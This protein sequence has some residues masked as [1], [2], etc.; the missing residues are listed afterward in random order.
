M[1]SDTLSLKASFQSL[2]MCFA[3]V[4]SKTGG[5]VRLH[6]PELSDGIVGV[7]DSLAALLSHDAHP[8]VRCLDHGHVVGT[9]TASHVTAVIA[10]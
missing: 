1:G 7:V 3:T 6:S 9:C 8:D 5:R 4:T 10:R 2:M